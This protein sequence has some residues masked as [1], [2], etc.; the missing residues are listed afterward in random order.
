[1]YYSKKYKKEYDDNY[2]WNYYYMKGSY[3]DDS[4]NPPKPETS[5]L[6][7]VLGMFTIC[8]IAPIMCCAVFQFYTGVD[9]FEKDKVEEFQ[10]D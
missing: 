7:I 3:Y 1:M 9:P 4:K 2:G 10:S 5:T 6:N 8:C